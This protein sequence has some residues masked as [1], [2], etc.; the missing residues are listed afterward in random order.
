MNRIHILG[1]SLLNLTP[2]HTTNQNECLIF[3]TEI[4][5]KH[6]FLIRCNRQRLGGVL[7]VRTCQFLFRLFMCYELQ[8][9]GLLLYSINS[10]PLSNVVKS[11]LKWFVRSLTEILFCRLYWLGARR[12]IVLTQQLSKKQCPQLGKHGKMSYRV[13]CPTHWT[14]WIQSACFPFVLT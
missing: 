2:A 6:P 7:I 9:L 11:L 10:S 13:S 12:K 14:V 8:A 5:N 4:P 1:R 3:A